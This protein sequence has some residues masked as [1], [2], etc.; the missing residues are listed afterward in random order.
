MIDHEPILKWIGNQQYTLSPT[1]RSTM[2]WE[3]EAESDEW[4]FSVGVHEEFPE[5]LLI[6]AHINLSEYHSGFASLSP[7]EQFGL[8]AH[9]KI[10]LLSLPIKR[11]FVPEHGIDWI[12][13]Q[14]F[15]YVE[16]ISRPKVLDAVHDLMK[17]YQIALWLFEWKVGSD[18]GL[19]D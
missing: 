11:L 18:L 15:V 4:A 12:D 2:L 10:G 1:D 5:D 3:Y 7:S 14:T 17:A 13:A 16:E 6:S 19:S 8:A 9:V